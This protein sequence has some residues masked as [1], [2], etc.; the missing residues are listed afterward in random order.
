M[1]IEPETTFPEFNE[2]PKVEVTPTKAV[3]AAQAAETRRVTAARNAAAKA[4]AVVQP[5]VAASEKAFN[6][7]A[8]AEAAEKT[9]FVQP[10]VQVDGYPVPLPEPSGKYLT[11]MEAFKAG[12]LPKAPEPGEVTKANGVSK[13]VAYLTIPIDELL[14]IRFVDKNGNLLRLD[15][16]SSGIY[17][18]K[19]A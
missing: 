13:K 19:P 1:P 17:W 2:K 12:K 16:K 6:L 8:A 15:V 7:A 14:N 3:A 10:E 11:F 4:K 18:I 5:E 9:A